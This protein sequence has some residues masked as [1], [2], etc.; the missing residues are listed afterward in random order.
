MRDAHR[1]TSSEI[2]SPGA[3]W[4]PA[5]GF[6]RRTMPAGTPGIRL[7]ADDRDAEAARAQQVGRAVAVDADEVGHDVGRAALAAIDEQRHRAAL[8][9]AG[10]ILRDDG[11]GG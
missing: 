3:I 8:L 5:C 6:W 9:L 4:K 1:L 2:G 7:I 11:P 10:G